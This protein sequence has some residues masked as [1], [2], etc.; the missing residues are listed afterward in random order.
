M[1]GH[2]EFCLFHQGERIRVPHGSPFSR[3]TLDLCS[4][5][6]LRNVL[7]NVGGNIAYK[8]RAAPLQ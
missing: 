1:V 7:K 4:R 8:M 2:S 6:M 5:C 3:E